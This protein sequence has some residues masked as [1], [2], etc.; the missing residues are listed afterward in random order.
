[1]R[2]RCRSADDHADGDDAMAA[3]PSACPSEL[4]DVDARAQSRSH[5]GWSAYLIEDRRTFRQHR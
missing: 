5:D 1:M 3:Y 2:A 4:D